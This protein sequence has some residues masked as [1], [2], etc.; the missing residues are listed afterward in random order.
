MS[1]DLKDLCARLRA[2]GSSTVGGVLDDMGIN[3][4]APALKPAVRGRR[5]AGP[6]FTVQILVAARGT[7]KPD[8]F[9]IPAYVDNAAEGEV[10]ALAAGGAAVSTMG[11]VAALVAKQRGIAAIVV[12]GGMRDF[13][14]ILETDL[15]IFPRHGVPVSGKTRVRVAATGVPI[16]LDGAL[17]N[18]GDILVGDDSGVVCVPRAVVQEVLDRAELADKKDRLMFEA[19]KKGMNLTDAVKYA[20][21]ALKK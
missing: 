5:F 10:I 19:V 3:G 1:S 12:D 20:A 14:E 7:F 2:L 17:V 13:D 21:A 9:N 16:Q 11:G 6:A 4:L 18:P 15:P 8:D